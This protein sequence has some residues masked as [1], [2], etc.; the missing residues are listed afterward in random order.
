M[1][2]C[3]CGIEMLEHKSC[4]FTHVIHSGKPVERIKA[5]YEQRAGGGWVKQ[6][7]V[8]HDCAVTFGSYHHSEC[9]VEECPICGEQLLSCGC[10][11]TGLEAPFT[12]PEDEL[13]VPKSEWVTIDELFAIL[14]N[15]NTLWGFDNKYLNLYLDTRYYIDGK[16]HCLVKDRNNNPITL[17]ELQARRL[18][19]GGTND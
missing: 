5:G 8:C 16:F 13:P 19:L 6:D 18:K 15:P 10:N 9:D 14:R 1:A 7:E 2:K 17:E 11:I 12:T 4:L 3:D